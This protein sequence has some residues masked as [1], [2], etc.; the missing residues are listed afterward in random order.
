MPAEDTVADSDSLSWGS[1]V[2]R[3]VTASQ[4]DVQGA[5][6][7]LPPS[8][9]DP[10]SL[11]PTL[12]VEVSPVC[13]DWTDNGVIAP[14]HRDAGKSPLASSNECLL[15]NVTKD[16]RVCHQGTS[17][18]G[19]RPAQQPEPHGSLGLRSR[20]SSKFPPLDA[21]QTNASQ[22]REAEPR[23][24]GATAGNRGGFGGGMPGGF[25]P[26]YG[27][28]SGGGGG[29]QIYVTNVSWNPIF[30]RRLLAL[31]RLTLQLVDPVQCWLA[32][33]ERPV[34]TS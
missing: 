29:R 26:G 9:S 24:I 18:A 13:S 12:G 34:S 27:G 8:L 16:C 4:W 6:A 14:C 7:T 17:P 11:S 28:A 33:L 30:H 23:F 20:G 25:N 1:L 19:C 31:S 32:R 2:C 5:P 10:L 15:A 22:D 3:R 21:A